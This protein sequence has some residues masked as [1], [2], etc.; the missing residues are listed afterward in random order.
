MII[1]INSI[2]FC[3]LLLLSLL[4]SLITATS[5]ANPCIPSLCLNGATCK[6]GLSFSYSC[7]C[8]LG[9]VGN[10]CEYYYSKFGL[11]LD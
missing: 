11:K 1:L 10:N 8:A 7:T 6:R 2:Q 4:P 5:V 3:Y 9:F